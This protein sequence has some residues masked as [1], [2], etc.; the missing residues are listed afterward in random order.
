MYHPTSA[1]PYVCGRPFD[2][3]CLRS[4]SNN[5][6][7]RLRVA[8]LRAATFSNT[9]ALLASRTLTWLT[10][11]PVFVFPDTKA[12][13]VAME[14]RAVIDSIPLNPLLRRRDLPLEV[15][16]LLRRRQ[17]RREEAEQPQPRLRRSRRRRPD[18]SERSP[19]SLRW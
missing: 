15:Q 1:V 5:S 12:V 14:L 6:S 3:G 19:A 17:R 2:V 11:Q 9:F 16:L 18:S 13:A 7:I 8:L 10:Y 4:S